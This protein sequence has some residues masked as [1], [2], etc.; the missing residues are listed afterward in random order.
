[1]PREVLLVL[2][3][4]ASTLLALYL[5]TFIVAL[6]FVLSFKKIMKQHSRSLTI[7]LT[8]KRENILK[9]FNIIKSLG[10]EV[11]DSI[12][13]KLNSIDPNIF[14]TPESPECKATSDELSILRDRALLVS[15][16]NLDLGKHNEFNMLIEHI[17]E[18][19]KVYRIKLA[20]YNA[21]V[22][23]YNYWINFLPTR[24]IFKLFKCKEKELI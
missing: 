8:T 4:V 11:D 22:L 5:L 7:L 16:S 9:I 6:I 21:D 18:I 12:F 10:I 15:A 2:I 1:M 3:I 23:G 14:M 24:F 19:D 13:E 17:L 20:M